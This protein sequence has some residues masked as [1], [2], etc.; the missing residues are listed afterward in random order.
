MRNQSDI[1]TPLASNSHLIAHRTYAALPAILHVSLL[2]WLDFYLFIFT[3]ISFAIEKRVYGFH[4][5][6]LQKSQQRAFD[7]GYS[8]QSKTNPNLN[9][10]HLDLLFHENLQK[11]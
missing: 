9:Y 10:K 4:I 6:S 1:D 11:A 3:K 5:I 2:C 7:N 8:C